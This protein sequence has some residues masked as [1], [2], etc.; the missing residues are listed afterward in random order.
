MRKSLGGLVLTISIL[1]F[2]GTA[3]A[4]PAVVLVSGFDTTTPFST[5]AP[6]CAGKEGETWNP[7]TGV[8][9]ALKGAGYTVFTAPTLQSGTTPPAPCLGTGQ[10]A[11]PAAATIDTNGDIDANGRALIA[12]F[13]FLAT[14][15]GVT[16]VQL[17]GHTDGGLWSRSAIGQMDANA[18]DPLTVQSLTTMGTPH[19][20]SFGA[21][22][23]VTLNNGTCDFSNEIEQLLCEGML[24][25]IQAEFSDL[26]PAT[27]EQLTSSFLQGWNQKQAIGCSV[28]VLGGTYVDFPLPGYRYYT[29]DDG[30]VGIA[31][32]HATA[33]KS[34]F[35]QPIPAPG[36]ATTGGASFPVV[37]SAVLTFLSPNTLLNQAG[38]SAT[39]LQYVKAGAAGKPCVVAGAPSSPTT[40]ELPPPASAGFHSLEAAS[41]ATAASRGTLSRPVAGQAVLLGRGASLRCNGRKIAATPL[42][43]ARQARV[44]FPRCK[45]ALRVKGGRAL[46][47]RPD[48]RRVLLARHDG[49][50]LQLSVRGPKLRGL[51]VQAQVGKRWRAVKPRGSTKL[52]ATRGRVT[53]RATGKTRDGRRLTAVTH[54]NARE[55]R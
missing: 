49:T 24:D 37:H 39:V 17:V 15:Y 46:A 22:L 45:R 10:T 30:I 7:S 4:T 33:A 32:A 23:A 1:A 48:R 28:S 53:V 16:S 26:G 47:L 40:T 29:P 13:Q 36:F 52:A 44:G 34:I 19:T 25:V 50:R 11:P 35:G 9:A 14:N 18:V 5:S 20:G 41:G 2:A 31:S 27:I 55:R 54:V 43:G 21:D 38:I 42:L 51:R 12:L 6:N 8:A 3:H